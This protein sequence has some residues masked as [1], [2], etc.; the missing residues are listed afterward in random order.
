MK[1]I[2]VLSEGDPQ[3]RKGMFNAVL[4]R[5]KHLNAITDFSIHA[6]LLNSYEPWYMRLLRGT[7]KTERKKLYAID[8]VDFSAIWNKFYLLD[9][10]LECKLHKKPI[11]KT[12]QDKNVYKKLK[13]ADLIVTHSFKT[14][15]IAQ[16]AKEKYGI[17]FCITWHGSDIHT[18][19][20]S[21]QYIFLKTKQLI[22]EA[23]C[24]MF[25]SK[26]LLETSNQITMNGYKEVL[27]NGCD[28][29]F[30]RYS[31]DE[32]MRLKSEYNTDGK[33]I[34]SFVGNFLE[35]K[36]ITIIPQIFKDIY[37]KN[38][39]LIFWMIGDGK[40]RQQ[41]EKET[42]DIPI[43]LWGNQAP[44]KIPDYLNCTDVLILPSKNEGLPL[45]TVEALKCGCNVVGSH[46]GGI[47][48]VIG[49]ENCVELNTPNFS[50]K[51]AERVC[52]YLN[53]RIRNLQILDPCFDWNTTAIKEK[54]IIDKILER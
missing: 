3:D 5:I 25:V 9:W 52:F 14:A 2:I 13:G 18:D 46:V 37:N 39:D 35:V 21:N 4:N 27:Y 44:E 32:V 19:P 54:E 8:G 1:K 7:K 41:V 45:V 48:E 33:K 51:I 20:F 10:F 36:N 40:Y 43:V 16:K 6:L 34:V 26:A 24:N 23:D 42:E 12:L 30:L 28:E 53:S 31:D 11:F 29:R 38:K 49:T 17:P 47:P 15:L 50:E 22:E